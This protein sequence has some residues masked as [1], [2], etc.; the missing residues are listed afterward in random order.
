MCCLDDEAPVDTVNEDVNESGHFDIIVMVK[1]IVKTHHLERGGKTLKAKS[2]LKDESWE[3]GSRVLASCKIKRVQ[4]IARTAQKKEAATAVRVNERNA[5][6][7]MNNS[8]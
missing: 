8:C 5:A 6:N 3:V 4:R 1:E 7:A 2:E